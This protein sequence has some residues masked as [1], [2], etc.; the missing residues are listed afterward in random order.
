M[1]S[2]QV[3]DNYLKPKNLKEVSNP[4]GKG[5][6]TG[7]CGDT[8]YIGFKANQD[9]IVEI[10]FLTDGCGP[11]VACGSMLT[12]LVEG[13]TL[14]EAAAIAQEDLLRTLGGLPES[15]LHCAKLAVDT[16]LRALKDCQDRGGEPDA[17]R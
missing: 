3:I 7:P 1:F 4:D 6:V 9:R 15:H 16:L 2:P 17:Q 10:G 5:I 8:M 11:T 14:T 12:Q 13:R